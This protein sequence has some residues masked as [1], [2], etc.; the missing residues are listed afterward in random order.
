MSDKKNP[1]KGSD[2]TTRNLT[3][4][5]VLFVVLIGVLFSV[6]SNK[7]N[8]SVSIPSSVSAADGY[9]IV[10]NK[11]A[12][13]QIDIWED[14]QCPNCRNFESVAGSYVNDLIRTGKVKA[15]F[16]PMTFIG[17]ESILAAAAAACTADD[18]KF[19]DMHAAIFANQPASENSG[20]WTNATLTAIAIGAGDK[21]KN[22]ASC[23]SSGKYVNWTKNVEADAAKKNVNATPTMFINGKKLDQAHYLDLNALKADFAAAGVK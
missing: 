16:H 15:V 21:S 6:L 22:L 5:M 2:N 23:I 10:F 9:G 11:D 19:L 20:Q 4:G 17:P 3:V 8:S 18:G 12:K 13:T 1:K 7:T 14:F